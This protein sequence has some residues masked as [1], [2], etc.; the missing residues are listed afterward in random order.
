MSHLANVIDE[1]AFLESKI[2]KL[3]NDSFS[4]FR[5]WFIQFNQARWDK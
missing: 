2:A 5:K 4:K 3:D 1:I